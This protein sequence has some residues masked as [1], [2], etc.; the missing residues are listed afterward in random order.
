MSATINGLMLPAFS[1]PKTNPSVWVTVES[2]GKHQHV[3]AGTY[4]SFLLSSSPSFP[5]PESLIQALSPVLPLFK[6]SA[7]SGSQSLNSILSEPRANK[8]NTKRNIHVW[9]MHFRHLQLESLFYLQRL[10]LFPYT[11]LFFF[12]LPRDDV[13]TM[14]RSLSVEPSIRAM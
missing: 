9:A 4:L 13:A 12:F 14:W 7:I 2:A 5:L 3:C 8:M 11:E 10:P 6:P 1:K